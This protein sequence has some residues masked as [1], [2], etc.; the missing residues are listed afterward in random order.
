V[1]DYSAYI[2]SIEWIARRAA[3]LVKRK[4]PGYRELGRC[5]GK[6]KADHWHCRG[7][8]TL[9]LLPLVEV[10]HKNYDRLGQERDSD[11]EVLCGK[12]HKE[13]DKDR[14]ERS[15]RRRRSTFF[16]KRV[17]GWGKKVYGANWRKSIGVKRVTEEFEAWLEAKGET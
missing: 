15:H 9:L 5:S 4:C 3:F 17:A 7:C 2:Q 11:L 10:H 8:F 1:I 6:V 12:C 14:R 16:A 13:A